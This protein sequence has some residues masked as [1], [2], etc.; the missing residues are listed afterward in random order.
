MIA[1]VGSSMANTSE[2]KVAEKLETKDC[3]AEAAFKV[4]QYEKMNGCLT[5]T[6]YAHLLG[7]YF[8]MCQSNPNPCV[9]HDI[10]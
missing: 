4:D 3:I 9:S 6:Q 8:R 5:D 7:V 1:F 10:N 2:V